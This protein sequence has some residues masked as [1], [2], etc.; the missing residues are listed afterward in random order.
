[1][2]IRREA[3]LILLLG[4]LTYKLVLLLFLFHLISISQSLNDYIL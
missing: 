1:M 3:E 4:H 2:D